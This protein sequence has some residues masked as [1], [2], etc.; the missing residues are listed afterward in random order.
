M[1]SLILYFSRADE[2]Y[3]V[4]YFDKGNTE[5]LAEYIKEFTNADMFKV[6]RKTPYAK[7]YDTCIKEAKLEIENNE[8]PEI[9]NT[10]ASIDDYDTIYVGNPVYWSYMPQPMV[11]QIEKLNWNGKVVRPFITHEGSGTASIPRQLEKLC[12]GATIKTPIAIQGSRVKTAKD[13][14][15]RWEKNG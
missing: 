5:L 13:E 6:E 1:K 8:R 11:T 3:G 7:D 9:L 10:L 4:G 14:I 2:N 12:T 15:E